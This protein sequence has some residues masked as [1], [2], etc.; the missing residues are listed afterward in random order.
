MVFQD[1]VNIPSFSLVILCK[2][3]LS[4][5]KTSQKSVLIPRLDRFDSRHEI[6]LLI[7]SRNNFAIPVCFKTWRERS[8]KLLNL[9]TLAKKM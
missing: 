8:P 4:W 5:T 2:K 9:E 1:V 3:C 7:P 6:D